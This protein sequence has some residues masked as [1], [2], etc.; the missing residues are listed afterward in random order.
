VNYRA[1]RYVAED[2]KVEDAGRAILWAIAYHADKQ[3]G[4]CW[5]SQR[6]LAR[7]AGVARSTVELLLRKLREA[8]ELALVLEGSGTRMDCWRIV[9][10]E[11]ASGPMAGPLAEGVVD[12]SEPAS[13]P[14]GPAVVDRSA[15]A[16]IGRREEQEGVEGARDA[17]STPDG[18]V[19]ARSGT[20]EPTHIADAIPAAYHAEMERR[21]LR[22][23]KRGA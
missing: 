7:N 4:E 2:C 16:P 13:G 17:G 21:R 10:H 6:T 15:G 22:K 20:T 23:P 11:D 8:G 9:G 5:A 1:F 12:R 19:A 14:I 18:A 3:T